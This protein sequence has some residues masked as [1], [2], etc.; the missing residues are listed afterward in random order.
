[1][2][3]IAYPESDDR[4]TLGLF[5]ES[6]DTYPISGARSV[7]LDQQKGNASP[8]GLAV[9]CTRGDGRSLHVAA[10]SVI[11]KVTRDRIMNRMAELHPAYGWG[12][13]MGYGT[14]KHREAI[15][16]LGATPHHRRSFRR[17]A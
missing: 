6:G 17:G 14:G 15:E 3:G 5:E 13:N 2:K 10:A 9:W 4:P 7:G 16:V 12:R 11:A 1:M 8:D